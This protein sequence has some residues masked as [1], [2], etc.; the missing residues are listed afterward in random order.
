MEEVEML[1]SWA[2]RIRRDPVEALIDPGGDI[3]ESVEDLLDTVED[4]DPNE[5]R[6]SSGSRATRGRRR[7]RGRSLIFLLLLLLFSIAAG[8]LAGYVFTAVAVL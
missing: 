3:V 5:I 2:G 7:L 6:P 4:V 8:V 1:P